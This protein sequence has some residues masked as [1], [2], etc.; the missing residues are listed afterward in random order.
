MLL[1]LP[2]VKR[3]PP[4]FLRIA[5]AEVMLGEVADGDPTEA[6]RNAASELCAMFAP[7][8]QMKFTAVQFFHSDEDSTM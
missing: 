6:G 4:I 1:G 2:I 3:T 5:S 8:K 7:R